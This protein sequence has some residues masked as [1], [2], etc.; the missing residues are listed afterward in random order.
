M[1]H[2]AVQSS[3][4]RRWSGLVALA[5]TVAF[6]VV[7][8]HAGLVPAMLAASGLS[9]VVILFRRRH[10]DGVGI[11]L[12]VTLTYTVV[13]ALAGAVTGSQVVY[14]GVGL[15]L[16]V[17]VAVTIAATAFTPRPAAAVLLPTVV[18]YRHVAADDPLYRR[19][20]AQLTIGW[21]VAEL[22]ATGWEA[23]HL[24]A[25]T[26]SEFVVTRTVIAWPVMAG[27]VFLLIAYARFRLD[28]HE[29]HLARQQLG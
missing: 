5:P 10:T 16:N 8:A 3:S 19:V 9:C 6:L 18:R 13:R 2:H 20:T 14:F 12:P 27:V 7:D 15:A 11:L 23:H 28:P 1:T 24:T 25:V 17:L 4:P 22:A 29:H 26:A 21:A